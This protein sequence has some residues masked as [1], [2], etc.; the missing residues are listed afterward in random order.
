MGDPK[1]VK[2]L[3]AKSEAKAKAKKAKPTK[4]QPTVAGRM[5]L[6]GGKPK[7]KGAPAAVLKLI[8]DALKRKG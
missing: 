3:I 4:Q 5:S 2:K 6:R 1:N 7:P 8:T